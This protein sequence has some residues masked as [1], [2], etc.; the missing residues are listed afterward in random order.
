MAQGLRRHDQAALGQLLAGER[1]AEVGEIAAVGVE[2]LLSLGGVGA[3][4]R[5]P[6]AQPMDDGLVAF[7]F[8]AAPEAADLAGAQPQQARGLHL[9]QGAGEDLLQDLENIALVLAHGDPVGG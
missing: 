2:N 6:A 3:A 7:G 5:G 1:G 9:G 4:V 8:E